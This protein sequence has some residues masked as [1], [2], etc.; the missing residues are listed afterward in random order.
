[1]Q[2]FATLSYRGQLQRLHRLAHGALEHYA[3]SAPRLMP[4]RHETN[5]TF[6][7]LAADGQQYVLRIHRPEGHTVEQI[8]S[9]L[10]WLTALS[11]ETALGIPEPV[12]ARDG[13]LLT[14]AAGPGVPEGRVCVLFRWQKG[15]FCGE[16]LTPRQLE[17]IGEFTAQLHTYAAQWQP[18]ADFRRGRVD[19]LTEQGRRM[20]WHPT[21]SPAFHPTDDDV[22]QTLVLVHELCSPEDAAIVARAIKRIRAVFQELGEGT[23]V[24]GLIH[25]DLHQENYFF[26]RGVPRAIDFDDCGWGHYLFDLNVTLLEVQHLPNYPALRAALLKGYRAIRPLPENHEHY[27]ETFFALRRIQLLLWML[28]SRE[29]PAFRDEWALQA[30][31][32][33]HQLRQFVCNS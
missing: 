16:N 26:Q 18:P 7:V 17:R 29:H 10:R 5:T 23:E 3:V 25:G 11:Q 9:E 4:L 1:M 30:R 15:R 2:P 13:S 24:F 31:D 12:L 20:L 22:N 32:E 21:S 19:T 28:E 14:I 8:R 33:L 6:R 27:L